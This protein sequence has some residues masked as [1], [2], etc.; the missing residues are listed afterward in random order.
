MPNQ[1]FRP[2]EFVEKVDKYLI[3]N[4]ID[5]SQ[6]HCYDAAAKHFATDVEYIRSRW[7]W[8]RGK[9]KVTDPGIAET[10]ADAVVKKMGKGYRDFK[11]NANGTA[12]LDIIT[13]KRIRTKEDAIRVA[14][15]DLKAWKVDGYETTQWEVGRK[16]KVTKLNWES[17]TINGEVDDKGNFVT[18]TLFRVKLK[19]SPRLLDEDLGLQKDAVLSLLRAYS[20]IVK[21]DRTFENTDR[22]LLLE[23]CTFDVHLGSLSWSEESGE[24]Y[25]IKIAEARFKN[26]VNELL[27]KVNLSK[28]E[29]IL[30]PIGNDLMNID[31]KNN[32]TANGTVVDTDVRFMKMLKIAKRLMIDTIGQLACIAPV[33]VVVVPGNHDAT[34][35]LVLGEILDCFFYND[36]R[37]TVYGSPKTR[38]YYQYGKT[39]IQLTH[40]DEENHKDLG[41]IFATEQKEMWAATEFRFCQVGHFHKN[42]K[43]SYISVDEFQGFQVQIIPT[44]SSATA[45][46]YKKGYH[47]LKQAK[48]FLFDKEGGLVGEFTTTAK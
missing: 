42:K 13:D 29:R 3:E 33:D 9:G 25:D 47:S 17:G 40:G 10:I 41:L 15:V 6:S 12:D 37:V 34:V 48:A 24:N 22:D 23:I 8:L 30:F 43:I 38:K 46:A 28:V 36:E 21:L 26:S 27:K 18:E 19:L 35:S 11:E 4:P 1:T 16:N 7:K 14:K 44:L 31:N 39:A 2:K 5:R 45:W 20:P 32:A